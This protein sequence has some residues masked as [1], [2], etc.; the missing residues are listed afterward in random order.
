MAIFVGNIGAFAG[1]SAFS[2]ICPKGGVSRA[3]PGGGVDIPV[4]LDCMRVCYPV[5]GTI[6]A[7]G[8]VYGPRFI[9]KRVEE[10]NC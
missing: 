1:D 9:C 6:K 8:C 10:A 3:G 2:S 7:Y 4:G 5:I